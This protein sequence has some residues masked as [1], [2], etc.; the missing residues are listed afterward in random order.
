[1]AVREKL[2]RY[3]AIQEVQDWVMEQLG[4]E[5]AER[6]DR[7]GRRPSSEVKRRYVRGMVINDTVRLDGRAL[8]E[9]RQITCEV[10]MLPRVHGSA[11]FTRGETQ[12]LATATLAHQHLRPAHRVGDGGLQKGF[13]MHYNFPPFS[14]GE[15]KRFGSPGRR[16]IGHGNLAERALHAGAAPPTRTSPTPCAW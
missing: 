6:H 5:Y 4:E 8:D 9:V 16:E 2:Q 10:G 15:A 12:G 1:M 3:A 14:T 7:G 13:M 11:L